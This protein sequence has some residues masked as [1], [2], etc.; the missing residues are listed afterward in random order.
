MTPEDRYALFVAEYEN[1]CH[2]LGFQV[3][4]AVTVEML[5][6]VVQARGKVV[7]EPIANWTPPKEPEQSAPAKL[8]EIEVPATNGRKHKETT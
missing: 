5:G 1:L 3:T 7:V 2:R 4:A 8:P 6:P